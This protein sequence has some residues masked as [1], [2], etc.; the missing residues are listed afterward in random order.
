MSWVTQ[1]FTS[2]LGR[3]YVMSIT[4]LFLCSF[5][6]IHLTG[7]LLTLVPDGGLT[8]NAFTHF[9]EN[10][11]LINIMEYVLFAGFIFHIIQ[12]LVIT[13]KNQKTRPVKY[14]VSAGNQNSR[15]YSRNMGV[16]GTIIFIF[17][18]IHMR[19]FFYELR[20]NEESFGTDANGNVDLYKVV[21]VTFAMLPY[22]LLYFVA[23]FA[24]GYHLWHGFQSAFRS[25]GI[26]HKNY[27]PAIE[28]LGKFYTIVITG[29]FMFLPVY[30]YLVQHLK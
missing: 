17:L 6:I 26:M 24:M 20:F 16:L 30:W 12:A 13:I 2:T 9:M 7:N 15:W 23:M 18:V 10:T 21:V 28:A 11:L 27:T 25:L 8:F 1:M 3:K 29:G 22:A 5:L 4:G 14:A 19:N